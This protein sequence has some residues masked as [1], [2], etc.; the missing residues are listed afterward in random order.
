MR[1]IAYGVVLAVVVAALA[2]AGCTDE[3]GGGGSGG[4]GSGGGGGAGITA[5]PDSSYCIDGAEVMPTIGARSASV[6]R[7]NGRDFKDSNGNGELD[8]YED[9]RLSPADRAADLV[10]LM[11]VDQ[12][13]GLLEEGGLRV[14][15]EDEEGTVS[16]VQID[17]I[18]NDHVRQTL[19]R[20][21]DGLSAT[22]IARH[23]NKL[24]E[25]AESLPLGI[26]MLITTD[27]MFGAASD[28]SSTMLTSPFEAPQIT[29][30]PLVLGL[31]AIDDEAYV[32]Q[33][34]AWQAAQLRAVG[35]R[36]MLGPQADFA[37]EPM[38]SRVNDTFGARADRVGE[39]AKAYIQGFQGKDDGVN[40]FTGAAATVKHFPG[41]G[42]SEN[43]MDSHTAWGRF[44][45]FPG[46]NFAAHIDVMRTAIQGA[47]PAALMPCYSIYEDQVWNGAPVEQ[48]GASFSQVLMIDLLRSDIGWHGLVTSDWGA[49][50][51]CFASGD[52]KQASAWGTD[53]WTNAQRMAAFVEAGGHQIGNFFPSTVMWRD[54]LSAGAITEAQI[55]V[56]AQKALEVAFQVGAFED[57]YV[58]EDQA[59]TVIESF[60]DEAHD[61]MMKA[62]TLLKNDDAILPLD[63]NSADQNGTAGIQ[64]FYDGFD[65]AKILSY[66]SKVA[67]FAAVD[68][69]ADADYAIIRV[70]ARH[71]IYGGLD[72]GVPLSY[73]DPIK[74]YDQ[75]TNMPSNVDS[76]ASSP[77]LFGT[78]QTNNTA[79]NAIADTIEAHIAAKGTN[80]K[81]IFVVSTNRPWIWSDYM[82]DT[83]VLAAD[84]GMTDEALLDMV[85]QMRD[86]IQDPS[87]Q[88]SG[89]LPMEMPSSQAAVYAAKEDVP[90]DTANP[91]F[92]VGAG[93]TA[94]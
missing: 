76:T 92:T 17:I 90:H 64:V 25:L 70:S 2:L 38:W 29:D 60:A 81:L 39:L 85:F 87:I 55:A 6:I 84:F 40:P 13:I 7:V 27:P 37:T 44:A 4:G 68:A 74:V 77:F 35:V 56:A 72:G 88:P 73:R 20:W 26:P 45:V 32:K 75:D 28:M 16:D 78:A 80:T 22:A 53:T 94:Y 1:E 36:W 59:V 66:T 69:I 19:L 50:G 65:D 15:P 47:N 57:P 54:A 14:T 63:A 49:V 61:A 12:Q 91:L 21:P 93:I 23:L 89:T 33:I 43:G 30:W 82:A 3:T 62:F 34:G 51:N 67:G 46:D 11:D 41:S 31:G 52:C 10:A 48:T 83:S 18:T 86:G 9:W 58:D 79:G 42:P 71:G 8:P 24:Q 5:C